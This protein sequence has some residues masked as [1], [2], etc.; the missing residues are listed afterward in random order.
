LFVSGHRE[1]AER[2]AEML[3]SLPVIVEHVESL[4]RARA[5]LRQKDYD[6]VL[7]EAVLADGNWLDALHVVREHPNEL[8]VIVTDAQAD[9]RLWS[10]A[11]NMGAFDL[12]AQPFYEPEVKRIVYNA[13]FRTT[14]HSSRPQ[15]RPFAAA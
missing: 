9:A 7:T 10:E 4:E 6:V 15:A 12:L 3:N 13:C 11:L 14:P 8:E 5:E 1:D 2:L